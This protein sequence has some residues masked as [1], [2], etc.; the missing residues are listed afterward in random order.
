MNDTNETEANLNPSK[1][2]RQHDRFKSG[3]KDLRKA[4]QQQR[5]SDIVH[6]PILIHKA[7][8]MHT[9]SMGDFGCHRFGYNYSNSVSMLIEIDEI[10]QEYRHCC[11]VNEVLSGI[12]Y[13]ASIR[14]SC[15]HRSS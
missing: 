5:M 15:W 14:F 9:E 8:S 13:P 3:L 6:I 4:H 2:F 11:W 1:M 10:A 12:S 7:V